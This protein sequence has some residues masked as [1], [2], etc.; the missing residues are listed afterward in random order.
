MN[1]PLYHLL[2][3]TF[4]IRTVDFLHNRFSV[5]LDLGNLHCLTPAIII[6]IRPE[7]AV[8]YL[9]EQF[10][11]SKRRTFASG[12]LFDEFGRILLLRSSLLPATIIVGS[13]IA[14]LRWIMQLLALLLA[15][16]VVYGL[17]LLAQVN[18]L[19]LI[20][21]DIHFVL[22]SQPLGLQRGGRRILRRRM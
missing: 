22:V 20:R 7:E 4:V 16:H 6:F 19:K 11:P 10:A 15:G 9:R 12:R 18:L 1:G 21:I 3:D 5:L 13:A 17:H 14:D 2:I 8:F